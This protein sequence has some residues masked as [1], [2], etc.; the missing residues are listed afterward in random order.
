MK[1][2]ITYPIVS[3]KKIKRRKVL[4][5]L[6]WPF[7][8]VIYSLPIINI[9]TGKPLW[10]IVV[11]YALYMVWELFINVDLVEL[12]R[13]SQFIKLVVHSSILL[14]LIDIFLSPGWAVEVISIVAFSALTISGIL[15]FTDFRRQKQNMLPLIVLIFL[16]MIGAILGLI[17]TDYKNYWALIVMGL[18][19]VALLLSFVFILK[20]DFINEIKKRTHVN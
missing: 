2:K 4:D 19:S 14:A 9:L 20:K 6:F 1:V 11:L 10:S 17:L 18:I 3:I 15:F 13:I 16:T 8:L 7:L 5:V 12:N